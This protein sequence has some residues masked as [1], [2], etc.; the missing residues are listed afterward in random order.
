MAVY[1]NDLRLKEIANGDESGTWGTSTN[2]NLK[3]IGE[4]LSFQTEAVF[5]ADGD[6]TT[7]VADGAE[8]PARGLFYKA[9][10]TTDLTA[11][12]VLTIGPGRS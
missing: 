8:D 3:L 7:T 5:D 1:T 10:S 9:T 6:K 2:L 4:S 12:R 11:T